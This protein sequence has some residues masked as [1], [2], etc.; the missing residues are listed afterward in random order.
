[1][2]MSELAG[3]MGKSVS[4]VSR[5]KNAYEFAQRFVDHVDEPGARRLAAEEFST[6]EEISKVSGL[7]SHLRDYSNSEYDE[8]R[9]DVFNMVRNRVF[10][11]YRDARYLKDFKDDPEKWAVLKM[12]E[13]HA[14]NR[15]ANELRAGN[16][17]LKAKIENLR[18]SVE[19]ALERDPTALSD[20][21]VDHL[22]EAVRVADSFLNPGV[23][24]FR[25]E[26]ARFTEALESASLTDIKSVVPDEMTKFDVALDDF[27]SRLGKH[28]TW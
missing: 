8:L 10:K 11:E 22:R 13:A 14:A 28:K 25:I 4:W 21:D 6:L 27:R 12:G 23:A 26:L 15:F 16:T 1:M 2:N 18:G 5:L 19:R 17:N 24:K 3:H 9:S 20:A 7:G